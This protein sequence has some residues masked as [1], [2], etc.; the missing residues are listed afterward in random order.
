MPPKPDN[1]HHDPDPE[2]YVVDTGGGT[3]F[4]P[5]ASG[6]RIKYTRAPG[7]VASEELMGPGGNTVHRKGTGDAAVHALDASGN[8]SALVSCRIPPPPK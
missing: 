7:S 6:T 4:G 8:Q 1:L 2:L 5:Y 3:V